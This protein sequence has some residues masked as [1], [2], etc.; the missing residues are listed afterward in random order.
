MVAR[1]SGG[2]KHK[3]LVHGSHAASQCDVHHALRPYFRSPRIRHNREMT[4]IKP[5]AH[6]FIEWVDEIDS[7]NSE[8]LRRVAA[9]TAHAP[10]ALVAARQTHGRGRAG[11][12]WISP[13]KL[14]NSENLCLSVLIDV[15]VPLAEL[16]PLTLALGV[17][18]RRVLPQIRLKW[19]NDLF[20]D[21]KKLGGILVEV[22]KSSPTSC[23][24]VAGIGINLRMP[25]TI[26][27]AQI[28]GVDPAFTDL[29]FTDLSSHGLFV[30]AHNLA[31]LIVTQFLAAANDYAARRLTNFFAEWRDADALAGRAL[32]VSDDPGC[33]DPNTHWRGLG[34]S[35]R[36][37]LLIGFGDQVR[38]LVAGEVRVRVTANA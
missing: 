25:Q 2:R 37:G 14:Q 26:E 5:T 32:I 13:G 22:A 20:L 34:I 23:T 31:P 6:D 15:A 3:P 16:A 12:R 18:A 30:S 11:R 35:T 19:P 1:L 36:G 4:K 8:L 29:V 28:N 38:E 27:I 7:T 21:G 17:A 10:Q 9:G 33:D 24:V